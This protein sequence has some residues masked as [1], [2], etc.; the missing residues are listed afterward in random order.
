M[1]R[2][3][4]VFRQCCGAFLFMLFW[5]RGGLLK[6]VLIKSLFFGRNGLGHL[7]LGAL[8]QAVEKRV[9]GDA[10]LALSL[11][12][13]CSLLEKTYLFQMHMRAA[14]LISPSTL[15]SI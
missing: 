1:P 2:S 13:I 10:A 6:I 7:G 4:L 11:I 14:V 15:R 9:G 8:L 5:F 3:L 12:H